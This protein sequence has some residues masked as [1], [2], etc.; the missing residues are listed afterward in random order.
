MEKTFR[1]TRTHQ[2]AKCPW[3]VGTDPFQIPHGY[4]PEKHKALAST[5]AEPGRVQVGGTMHVMACHHSYNDAPAYCVGWLMHQLGPG[6][7]IPLRMT[8]RQCENIGDIVLEGNQHE[9]FEDTL[10]SNC[11]L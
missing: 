1:L 4:D 11:Q 2:C 3:K 5:I 7:N 9:R 10:P 6:N 8:M